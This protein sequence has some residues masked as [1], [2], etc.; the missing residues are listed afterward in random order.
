[1]RKHS[2]LYLIGLVCIITSFI[3]AY[4]FY[5]S[6]ASTAPKEVVVF[7]LIIF[8]VSVGI[9][10]TTICFEPRKQSFGDGIRQ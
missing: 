3:I 10:F 9:I 5:P 4:G 6:G 7:V 1:M 8:G 2:T